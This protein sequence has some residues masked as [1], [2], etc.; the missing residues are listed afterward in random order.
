MDRCVKRK[1]SEKILSSQMGLEP[2]T[3]R[4]LVGCANHLATENSNGEQWSFV[5]DKTTAIT[6][7]YCKKNCSKKLTK[8]LWPISYC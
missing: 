5:S 8:N 4:T 3:F 1:N 7:K 6:I 2:T